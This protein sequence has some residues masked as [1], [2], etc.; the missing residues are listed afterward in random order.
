M[1]WEASVRQILELG[2]ESFVEFGAG[3]VLA[4]MIKKID[5]KIP[6]YPVYDRVSL[7]KAVQGISA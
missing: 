4:G 3:N 5:R 6:V 7:E 1:L 2:V